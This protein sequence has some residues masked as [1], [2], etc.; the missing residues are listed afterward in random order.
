V[1]VYSGD[2]D[3]ACNW[4]GGRAWTNEMEWKHQ[5]EY[6]AQKFEDCAYGSCQSFKNFKFIKFANSG[7]MVP[8]DQPELALEMLTELLNRPTEKISEEVKFEYE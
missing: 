6:L 7:H 8:M 1:Y 2:K 5:K 4:Y 3:F